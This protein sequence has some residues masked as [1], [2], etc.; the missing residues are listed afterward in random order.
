MRAIGL[1]YACKYDLTSDG[2]KEFSK[3]HCGYALLS[4]DQDL[5]GI[6]QICSLVIVFIMCFWP[7][8]V[9]RGFIK[10]FATPLV[11]VYCPDGTVE[12]FY[13]TEEFERWADEHWGNVD[14]PPTGYKV[15]YYKGIGSHTK[16]EKQ[17]MGLNITDNIY[18]ITY[19]DTC[20]ALM[21]AMYGEDTSQRKIL[22]TTPVADKYPD[23]VWEKHQISLSTHFKVESKE[24]QLMNMRRKLRSCIDGL[25]PTQRKALCGG[26]RM[27]G[28]NLAEAKVFQVGA[29]VAKEMHYGQGDSSMNGVIMKLAQNFEGACNAPL[30]VA[31]SD[32]FGDN[33]MGREKTGGA[34]YLD[35]KYN[36]KLMDIMYPREDDWLLEYVREDRTK[37]EP[38]YYI[39]IM[40]M[41][42][43]ESENTTGT[44]WKIDLCGRDFTWTL[45]EVR[46]MIDGF[47]ALSLVGHPWMRSKGLS[48]R[49]EGGSEVSYGDYRY[50]VAENMIHVTQLPYRVWSYP[51]TCSHLGIDPNTGNDERLDPE[52]NEL[53]K[54]EKTPHII[55]IKDDTNNGENDIKVYLKPNTYELILEEYGSPLVDPIEH[56]LGLRSVMITNINMIDDT[57]YVHE[58]S[59]Y[60]EVLN[61]WFPRR[62]DL[63]IARLERSRLLLEYQLKFYKEIHR[64][65]IMDSTKAIN[66]DKDFE[67][68]VRDSILEQA[69]FVRFNKK[70]ILSPGFLRVDQLHAAVFV[71]GASY[72]YISN[73]T[74]GDQSKKAIALLEKK[75]SDMELEFLE[76]NTMTW[77]KLWLT[78]LEKLEKI[79]KLGLETNWQ[80]DH[81][82]FVF[83]NSKRKK[84]PPTL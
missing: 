8:L 22:L 28:G 5:D 53:Y 49:M 36:K 10:R 38:L 44:G 58:F 32:G 64:F 81:K 31:V 84:K 67:D 62:R 47:P 46:R 23:D 82:K 35:T 39:P 48:V 7:S 54:L 34:R 77:Q 63:Y 50:V 79:L 78:E 20:E 51:W 57:N 70:V 43:L 3:L 68:D 45:G 11:R 75:L 40:P 6:G 55:K 15:K 71:H 72:D 76:L 19:D 17:N 14:T 13:S 66:I 61:Y 41:A 26:R 18:T 56:F 2:N 1:D 83:V 21:H 69:G 30:F 37:C 73:I 80:Y 59:D 27:F 33:V 60:N 74:K 29:Y 25:I 52:T 9:K 4:T 12:E 65:I 24:F 42:I 16:E